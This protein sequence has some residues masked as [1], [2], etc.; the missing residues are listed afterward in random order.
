MKTLRRV[1]KY[2]PVLGEFFDLLDKIDKS[3]DD[4][5]ITQE[6]RNNLNAEFRQVVDAA[7]KARE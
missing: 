6:E 1:M 4:G 7:R 5:H 2:W 3:L